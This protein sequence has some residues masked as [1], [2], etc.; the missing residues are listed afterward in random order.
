MTDVDEIVELQRDYR[1]ISMIKAV[2]L[3]IF[4]RKRFVELAARHDV[5][6][7]VT[8]NPDRIGS[9]HADPEELKRYIEHMR[10]FADK[11]FTTIHR[12]FARSFRLV[13]L[14]LAAGVVFGWRIARLIGELAPQV[15]LALQVIGAALLLLAAI[16][17][18]GADEKTMGG[19]SLVERVYAH[20]FAALCVLGTTALFVASTAGM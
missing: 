6:W 8:L 13:C 16:W 15:G 14:S 7:S 3:F 10:E 18:L 4:W 20:I 19:G 17:Q 2:A 12:S 11:R 5:G 1:N 9:L